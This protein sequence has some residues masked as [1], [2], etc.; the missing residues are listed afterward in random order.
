[1]PMVP[2]LRSTRARFEEGVVMATY[3]LTTI[4]LQ[5]SYQSVFEVYAD[6]NKEKTIGFVFDEEQSRLLGAA[7]ELLE[8][9]I[10]LVDHAQ[11]AYPHF[12]SERG[13]RD[14]EQ[15]K[16]A[17]AKARGKPRV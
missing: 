17:I 7:E 5:G 10:I 9:L 2:A 8:A 3:S 15:A 16:V 14:I 6:E 12:E 13:Q 4:S 1:M 11:E